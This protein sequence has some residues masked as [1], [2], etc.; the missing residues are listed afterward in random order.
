MYKLDQ[1]LLAK[2]Q[3]DIQK[4]LFKITNDAKVLEKISNSIAK[5][6]LDATHIIH[7]A[8]EIGIFELRQD[9]AKTYLVYF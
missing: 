1:N 5:E 6:H 8:D 4:W 7:Q 3:E 9:G 2:P